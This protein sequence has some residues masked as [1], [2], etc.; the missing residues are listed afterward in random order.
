VSGQR[1]WPSSTALHIH[2]PLMGDVPAS[3]L[4]LLPDH[5]FVGWL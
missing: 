3:T 4:S 2:D 5:V 1:N